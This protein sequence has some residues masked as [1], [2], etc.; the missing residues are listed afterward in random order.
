VNI[1]TQLHHIDTAQDVKTAFRP[2]KFAHP[3]Y[4]YYCPQKSNNYA[5]GV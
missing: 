4:Y 1:V 5:V 3:P 2:H